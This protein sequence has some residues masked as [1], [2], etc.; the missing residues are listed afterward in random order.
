M[1][2]SLGTFGGPHIDEFDKPPL[3]FKISSEE[4]VRHLIFKFEGQVNAFRG[5]ITG[6]NIP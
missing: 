3:V 5:E 2:Q 6:D 4:A 1:S